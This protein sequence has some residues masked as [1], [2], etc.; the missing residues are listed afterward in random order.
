MG[1]N[2]AYCGRIRYS[3]GFVAPSEG[4][5]SRGS[6]LSCGIWH[7]GEF[8]S[9]NCQICVL[10]MNTRKMVIFGTICGL[11]FVRRCSEG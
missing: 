6:P 5:S 2:V 3:C 1:A 10:F 4:Q 7:N 8:G 9:A 11:F